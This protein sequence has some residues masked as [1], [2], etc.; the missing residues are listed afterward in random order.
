VRI[1]FAAAPGYGL[2]L[3]IV[4]LIWAARAAGHEV[5]L[6]TTS[7][8]T[9][10]SAA[11]GLPVV[12]VH[13]DR[14]LWS[15]LMGAIGRPDALP[16][17]AAPEFQLASRERAPFA[18]FTAA[19]TEGTIQ[20]A[21]AFGADL[22]VYPSDHPAGALTAAAA[23]LP[24]LEVGNRVSWS[25]RDARRAGAD[26]TAGPRFA[27]T[28]LTQALQ[29]RLQI[30][31]APPR[32]VARIDPR[33]PSM[34]GLDRDELDPLD[35]VPWWPMRY[36][37]YN[38]GAVVPP[39]ALAEPPRPR[40][41]V[42][43]GTVVPMV[44][45]SSILGVVLEALNDL[46]VDVVL[47]AGRADLSML[48]P[49]PDNV[50]SVGYLPLSAF[51]AS[52]RVLVHHGGSGTTAAPLFYGVPQ[53]VLPSFA[54]GPL[55][56]QRVVDRGVG[57]SDDPTTVTSD[58]VRALVRRLIDE[59]QFSQ[60]AQEVRTEMANQPSPAAIMARVADQLPSVSPS[61]PASPPLR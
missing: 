60:A 33:P 38:G 61:D 13:P 39:W 30:P 28:E 35:Q 6:A 15:T 3:P 7:E 32:L 19:M 2:L 5:L 58:R 43:L 14:A 55:S 53:L 17:G 45:G 57:L 37:P 41:G 54:D 18:M 47:A 23:D 20:A 1:L 46:E 4:P 22:M 12:D 24:G 10:V 44:S 9:D 48:G 40:V 31:D 27:S 25:T 21:R 51:L 36:V 16:D 34:G 8:M 59:P 52:C 11:A 50:N 29:T 49:L 42:T 26:A 56:A